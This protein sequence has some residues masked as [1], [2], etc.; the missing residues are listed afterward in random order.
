MNVRSPPTDSGRSTSS[1]GISSNGRS[2]DSDSA[3]ASPAAIS[4][5]SSSC[6]SPNPPN[7]SPDRISSSPDSAGS[8]PASGA[9]SGSASAC[10]S[11][12]VCSKP[13]MMSASWWL[14]NASD[15]T[16]SP[17]VDST[18]L[19]ERSMPSTGSTSDDGSISACELMNGT[20]TSTGLGSGSGSGA[21]GGADGWA[22]LAGA[23]D[24]GG[25]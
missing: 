19:A 18:K 3:D 10:V 1:T 4:S 24:A 25:A 15:C 7:G 11:N 9:T 14:T 12:V 20:S 2:M 6:T 22:G 16:A 8:S 21:G 23:A 17:V 5:V 13:T